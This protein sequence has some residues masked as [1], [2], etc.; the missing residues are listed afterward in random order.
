VIAKELQLMCYK[1][2]M[3]RLVLE[4]IRSAI[5]DQKLITQV[6]EQK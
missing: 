1:A 6:S 2:A 3:E 4:N 5:F